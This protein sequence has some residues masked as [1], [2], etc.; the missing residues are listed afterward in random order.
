M[1]NERRRNNRITH[2]ARELRSIACQLRR[3]DWSGL[4]L[5]VLACQLDAMASEL[6]TLQRESRSRVLPGPGKRMQVHVAPPDGM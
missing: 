4:E 1:T 2:R 3:I 5:K 6:D